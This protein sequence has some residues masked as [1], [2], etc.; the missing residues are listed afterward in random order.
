MIKARMIRDRYRGDP[1]LEMVAF[2]AQPSQMS[3]ADLA[4]KTEVDWPVATMY[5]TLPEEY[6]SAGEMIFLIDPQGK[7]VAKNLNAP[8]AYLRVDEALSMTTG[9]SASIGFN[10]ARV[11][12]GHLPSGTPE[13]SRFA[14]VPPVSASD[15]ATNGTFSVVDGRGTEPSNSVDR[16]KDGRE[17][18]GDDAPSQ[19]F[20]F[21]TGTL[22][23]RLKLDLGKVISVGQVNSYSR[24]K[25]WRGPQIYVLYGSDG[26]DPEF[27][28]SPKNGIDPASVGWKEIAV[29][30]GRLK[31]GVMG[32]R[33]GVSVSHPSGALGKYRYLLFEMFPSETRDPFGQAFYGEIDVVE[34]R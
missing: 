27:N 31:D 28:A 25:N 18:S 3:G 13:G 4:K 10:G 14:N 21:E 6:T 15:A 17:A 11:A 24:H 23:G 22:E 26:T 29:V 19:N 5:T 7:L 33:Y 9:P 20:F 2:V 16:L 32:G 8:T 1:R 12:I 34:G 30:D